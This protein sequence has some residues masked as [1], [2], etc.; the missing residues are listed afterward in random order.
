MSYF[1]DVLLGAGALGAAIYC[2]ILSR[3]L[4]ALTTLDSTLGSAIA[5]L[6]AQV[7]ELSTALRGA[8]AAAV[9]ASERL[10]TQSDR[11]EQICNRMELLAAALHDVPE[12]ATVPVHAPVRHIEPVISDQFTE[13]I[14][15][16]NRLLRRRQATSLGVA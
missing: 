5:L 14:P 2:L 7:D 15:N 6:S 1:S 13:A 8:E 4:R 10:V 11:A 9:N 12:S 3:R 16:R